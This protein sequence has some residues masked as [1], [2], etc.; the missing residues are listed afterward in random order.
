MACLLVIGVL[1]TVDH[2]LP[3]MVCHMTKYS[4]CDKT[5]NLAKNNSTYMQKEF[6]LTSNQFNMAKTTQPASLYIIWPDI[7]ECRLNYLCMCKLYHFARSLMPHLKGEPMVRLAPSVSSWY[8][9]NKTTKIFTNSTQFGVLEFKFK[10][11]LYS[12]ILKKNN[13]LFRFVLI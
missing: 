5:L 6:N 12:F 13:Y 8:W 1:L 3:A 4:T 11:H 2:Q 9:L 7:E 10:I